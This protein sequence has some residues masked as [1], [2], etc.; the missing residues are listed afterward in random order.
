MGFVVIA[1]RRNLE[2]YH[3]AAVDKP[4]SLGENEAISAILSGAKIIVNRRFGRNC[5]ISLKG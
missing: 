5:G 1:P 2:M 3:C 4:E